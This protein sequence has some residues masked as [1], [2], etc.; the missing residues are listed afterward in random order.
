MQSTN[1][2]AIRQ[3]TAERSALPKIGSIR[4][5]VYLFQGRVDFAF[6]LN[7][8]TE[9]FGRL[10][11]PKKLYAGNFGHPPSRFPGPDIAY[12][13]SQGIAWFDHF[14]KGTANG[15]EAKPVVIAKQGSRTVR[16]ELSRSAAQRSCRPAT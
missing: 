14:L 2:P 1:P 16:T 9:A 5:P 8:A 12:V 3:L 11:G 7:Q 10:R 4:T 15:V 13:R 6:D